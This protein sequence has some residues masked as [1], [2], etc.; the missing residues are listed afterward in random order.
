MVREGIEKYKIE[1]VIIEK[2]DLLLIC[3]DKQN[4]FKA[5]NCFQAEKIFRDVQIFVSDFGRIFDLSSKEIHQG[6]REKF[7]D[8][9]EVINEIVEIILH[10]KAQVIKA[11]TS[12]GLG[13]IPAKNL[14]VT[15]R[16]KKIAECVLQ[17]TSCQ[18]SFQFSS[19]TR[20]YIER[21]IFLS[22]LMGIEIKK[23]A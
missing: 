2:N 5:L 18:L 8:E 3:G 10:F 12:F 1:V 13:R 9:T 20:R 19:K 21:I 6:W 7:R 14:I 23:I 16:G 22:G 15:K 17:Q 4:L 11:T